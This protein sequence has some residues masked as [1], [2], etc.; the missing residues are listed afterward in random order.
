MQLRDHPSLYIWP[1]KWVEFREKKLGILTK[2]PI[3]STPIRD[4]LN[5]KPMDHAI[6]ANLPIQHYLF[7]FF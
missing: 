2:K 3:L 4:W 1:P 6:Y 7:K 5:Q